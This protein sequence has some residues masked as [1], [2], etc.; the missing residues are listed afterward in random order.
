MGRRKGSKNRKSRIVKVPKYKKREDE[1]PSQWRRSKKR[2]VTRRKGKR[3]GGPSP[4]SAFVEVLQPMPLRQAFVFR[5]HRDAT[6][7][8][9]DSVAQG[10]V[11]RVTLYPREILVPKRKGRWKRRAV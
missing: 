4:Y 8:A 6:A 9:D 11:V 1:R 3:V 7:F 2:K 10:K 5:K